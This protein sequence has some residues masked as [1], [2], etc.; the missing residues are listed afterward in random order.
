MTRERYHREFT[1]PVRRYYDAM[2]FDFSAE[3]FDDVAVEYHEAYESV[4]ATADV[5]AD[6]LAALER[7]SAAGAVQVILSALE[8]RR[9][10]R[11]LERRGLDRYFHAVYGLNDL[12]AVSKQARGHELVAE[13]RIDTD[14][15][16][17]VGDTSHDAEVA[18][19]IGVR[20]VLVTGGHSDADRLAS[21]GCPVVPSLLA[22][23][24]EMGL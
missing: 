1:F 23:L 24:D 12:Y 5:R 16:W 20:P 21:F 4:V 6:A 8:E 14:T 11:E 19:A 22:A 17:M 10:R 15:A 3:T 9:L 7:A 13:L 2:G 18:T